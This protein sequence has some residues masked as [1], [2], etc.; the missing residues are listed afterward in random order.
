MKTKITLK[1][2]LLLGI[3]GIQVNAISQS[4]KCTA[5][6]NTAFGTIKSKEHTNNNGNFTIDAF[7]IAK[8]T[9]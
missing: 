3:L 5:K 2:M 1:I 6:T 4:L 8:D 9:T 7:I